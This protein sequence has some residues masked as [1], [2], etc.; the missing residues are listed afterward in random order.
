MSASDSVPECVAAASTVTNHVGWRAKLVDSVAAG[1]YLALSL[2]MY[3]TE[4]SRA[5][6]IGRSHSGAPAEIVATI[7]KREM[8]H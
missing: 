4:S 7:E 5:I 8:S 6:T 3:H 1:L 2:A